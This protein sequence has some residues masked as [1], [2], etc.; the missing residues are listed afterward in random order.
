[1]LEDIKAM[2]A[3]MLE[4]KDTDQ[5]VALINDLR[6]FIHEL[7]PMNDEPGDFIRWV[8][9]EKVSPNDYNPNS[10]A[11]KEMS[12]LY[13][14]IKEDGVTMPVVTIQDGDGFTI[15]DG[16]HRY[17]TCKT[18]ED[19]KK[20]MNGYLPIT[21]INKSLEERIAAT[22]RHNRARGSHS[23]QGMSNL[24]FKMLKEGV[25]DEQIC[26]KLGLDAT[27]LIKLKH[28][29]GYSKL[30]EDAEYG[31]AWTT[32]YQIRAKKKYLK[33]LKTGEKTN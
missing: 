14:S 8:K 21:V 13:I 1:M 4:S 17:F 30:Y 6:A 9:V 22:V 23:V 24:V 28:I 7:S 15:V 18:M 5:T 32:D 10:T 31:K 27:E 2:I 19:L 3:G 29:T 20:R 26:N 25:S 16:F 33:S 11:G 12:L